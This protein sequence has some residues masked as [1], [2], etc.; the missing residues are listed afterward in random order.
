MKTVWC[1]VTKKGVSLLFWCCEQGCCTCF[2]FNALSQHLNFFAFNHPRSIA[3]IVFQPLP[4][5][6]KLSFIP[7]TQ[8]S[9]QLLSST[10]FIQ[11]DLSLP[12][13]VPTFLPTILHSCFRHST[14]HW[15][16]LI[17]FGLTLF[18][19]CVWCGYISCILCAVIISWKWFVV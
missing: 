14:N 5:F 3:A 2:V 16:V 12:L 4:T 15:I 6:F 17:N 8:P 11:P 9:K 18:A 10:I 7:F 1:K 13:L 19:T